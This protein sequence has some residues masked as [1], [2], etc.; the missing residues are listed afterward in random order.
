MSQLTI[1]Q[2]AKLAIG[3]IISALFVFWAARGL[4]L[5][6]V[7]RALRSGNYIW[8]IPASAAYAL[9]VLLRTWRWQSLLRPV[10]FV[11]I[12]RLLPIIVIGYMGNN[13]LPA[14]AG[15]VLRSY[16]LKKSE[17]VSITASLATIVLERVFDAVTMLLFLLASLSLFAMTAQNI[18]IT[19]GLGVFCLL[20]LA[21]FWL[22]AAKHTLLKRL[23]EWASGHFLPERLR[24][25]VRNLAG[26]FLEGLQSLRS[27]RAI[28]MVLLQS[29]GIWL[30]EAVV[31]LAVAQVFP[32]LRVSYPQLVF[33]VAITALA[34]TLPSTPG[35]VGTFDAPGI[36]V[37]A[38]F[39][40]PRNLAASFTVV[41]HLVLWLPITVAGWVLMAASSVRWSD[42]AGA[43]SSEAPSGTVP[44]AAR[45]FPQ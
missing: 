10:R 7:A 12:R 16:V 41:L 4:R 38:R 22:V 14:R 6:E 11:P 43:F 23:Y 2:K 19:A 13:V 44:E 30:A 31:Y 20:V 37:L 3:L 18:W 40:V 35:Y 24:E 25:P 32:G 34:T 8:L 36:A 42:A 17:D 28:A 26:R 15:E 27:P 39:G 33:M 29:A 9:P 21:V 5:D 45:E 1:A